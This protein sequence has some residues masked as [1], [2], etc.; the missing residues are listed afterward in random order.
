MGL[1]SKIWWVPLFSFLSLTP[2]FFGVTP[3]GDA[4]YLFQLFH[5]FYSSL[6]KDGQWLS[7][8]SSGFYGVPSNYLEILFFSP[9]VAITYGIGLLFRIEDVRAL[10][11]LLSWLDASVLGIGLYLFTQFVL[12]SEKVGLWISASF[13]AVMPWF[14]DHDF[15]LRICYSI[16]LALYFWERFITSGRAVYLSYALLANIYGAIGVPPY[17]WPI[18]LL[19]VFSYAVFRGTDKVRLTLP[20]EDF[21][22]AFAG[23]GVVLCS[24]FYMYKAYHGVRDGLVL[25]PSG[26]NAQTGKSELIT[27]LTYGGRVGQYFFHEW[28]SG[29]RLKRFPIHYPGILCVL[30]SLRVI[31]EFRAAQARGLIGC[32]LLVGLVYAGGF[33][34]DLLYHFFPGISYYRH[35]G[36]LTGVLKIIT[37]LCAGFGLK[38]VLE[39]ERQT[40]RSLA[41]FA[42]GSLALFLAVDFSLN[43]WM[44]IDSIKG[45]CIEA[46]IR[47]CKDPRFHLQAMFSYGRAFL[48]IAILGAWMFGKLGGKGLMRA[49]VVFLGIEGL[50]FHYSNRQLFTEQS[51]SIK[52]VA[53][54]LFKARPLMGTAEKTK[55]DVSPTSAEETAKRAARPDGDLMYAAL[56]T[57]LN[58]DP[59]VPLG[60]VDFLMEG[61]ARLFELR[62]LRPGLYWDGY[63]ADQ[64]KKDALLG[65][66]LGC[67]EPKLRWLSQPKVV[68]SVQEAES[69]VTQGTEVIQGPLPEGQSGDLSGQGAPI[70]VLKSGPG[71]FE[72][73][74]SGSGFLYFA[75]AWHPRWRAKVDGIDVPI[76]RANLGFKAIYLRGGQNFI[77]LNLR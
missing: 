68:S 4:F 42:V 15:S 38:W 46:I 52:A 70:E 17:F 61:V 44:Q 28:L 67:T 39:R 1:R 71:V 31:W 49:F 76:Y 51:N 11:I 7:W 6:L 43:H 45:A 16:P 24:L 48:L 63:F 53:K 18:S 2:Y 37:I 34:A 23:F 32:L 74:T 12:K 60:R 50:F 20:R 66:A 72:L 33:G 57:F 10:F 59:C 8:I 21:V 73:K 47:K 27:F 69:F 77:S 65:K 54:E 75:D 19:V 26:R 9:T 55:R 35:I 30:L 40:E 3:E 41:A 25:A 62:K 58:Q 56:Y 13:F 5:S 14:F 29:V 64:V 22:K 36:H